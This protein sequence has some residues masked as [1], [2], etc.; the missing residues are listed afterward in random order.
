[1]EPLFFCVR[2]SY[3]FG[4]LL[5]CGVRLWFRVYFEDLG[6]KPPFDMG[7]EEE[8]TSENFTFFRRVFSFIKNRRQSMR[9]TRNIANRDRYCAHGRLVAAYFSAYPICDA[10]HFWKKVPNELISALMKCTFAIHQLSYRTVHDALDEYL[11]TGET[12]SRELVDYFS[13]FDVEN[14]RA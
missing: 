7:E 5:L 14:F 3:L 9:L 6:E 10:Y 8:V 13:K 12:T 11:Q 2:L 1:M 4:D